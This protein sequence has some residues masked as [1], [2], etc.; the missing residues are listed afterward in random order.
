MSLKKS[1][2]PHTTIRADRMDQIREIR[3]DDYEGRIDLAMRGACDVAHIPR[4][5]NAGQILECGEHRWQVMFNG[6]RMKAGGYYGAWMTE[7]IR[8]LGGFHEPQEERVFHQMLGALKSPRAMVEMGAYWAWYSLWFK[9]LFPDAQVIA[10]EPDPENLAMAAANAGENKLDLVLELGGIA[11]PSAQ[12][13]FGRAFPIKP[14]C[15][16]PH[17]T[18]TDI[19]LK[20]GLQHLDVLH[21]DIQGAELTMLQDLTP[22]L[23]ER[24][25]DHIFVS[26]HSEIIHQ[27]CR[28]LLGAAGYRIMAEHTPTESY[29]FDG[30]IAVRSPNLPPLE[31]PIS[32]YAGDL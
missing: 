21:A 27:R 23:K 2:D 4:I 9:S 5:C 29:S 1:C 22:L 19:M 12:A 8:R 11:Q 10:V 26:T 25:I 15:H 7:L 24:R 16:V 28:D 14:Y 3:W 31:V 18:V 32:R 20:Y 17:V 6:L 13:D 30:L